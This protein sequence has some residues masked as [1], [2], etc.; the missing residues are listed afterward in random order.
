MGA[1]LP[2]QMTAIDIA[3]PGGPDVLTPKS[4]AVPRPGRGEVLIK[5]AAAGVNRPDI[6]Q[7]QGH[8]PAP[9][10]ASPVPGLEVAGTVAALGEA[11]ARYKIGDRVCALVAGGG[12]GEYCT[13]PEGQTLPVPTGLSFVEAAAV[14]ETFFTVWSN[15]FERAYAGAGDRLLVHGGTSGIGTTAIMLAKAFGLSV[16]TTAGSDEKCAQCRALGADVAINYRE[17]DFVEMVMAATDGR[18]VDIVLDMV[19]GAYIPRNIACLAENGRHVSIAFLGGAKAEVNFMPVMLKRL[20][21]TGSTLRARS[22]AFKTAIAAEL[23]NLVWPL[24]ADGTIKPLI[25]SRFAL[26]QAGEAHRRMESSQH[27]GKIVLVAA[28]T[29]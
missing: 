13:A 22:I 28:E 9:P 27:M 25:D 11:V 19:G 1:D 8:Y 12:Y 16:L 4:M 5:V 18:G 2:G 3:E 29:P 14:P 7:R 6:V 17:Q 23:E 10:G 15:V 20:T 26:T 24:L 21:L